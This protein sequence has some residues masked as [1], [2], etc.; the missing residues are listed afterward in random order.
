MVI[1]LADLNRVEAGL[2]VVTGRCQ[3]C[4][5]DVVDKRTACVSCEKAPACITVSNSDYEEGHD[6]SPATPHT[7]EFEYVRADLV[8]KMKTPDRE[9]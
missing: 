8:E 5:I 3:W 2:A 6:V 9:P 4:G 7:G 1:S